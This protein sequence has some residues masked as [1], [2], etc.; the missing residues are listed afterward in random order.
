MRQFLL[1]AA[2]LAL[3]GCDAFGSDDTEIRVTG[4]VVEATTGD[5]VPGIA[6][7]LYRQSPIVYPFGETRTGAD[8]R[9]T[10]EHDD[11]EFPYS[12]ILGVN[13]SPYSYNPAYTENS[14]RRVVRGTV[15]DLGDIE[16]ERTGR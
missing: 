9:F 11:G 2:L 15:A 3:A 12:L 5:P 7:F 16:V 1:L 10:V 14:T 6:V 8:G 13:A 4:R